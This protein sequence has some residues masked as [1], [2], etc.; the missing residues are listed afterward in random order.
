MNYNYQMI[1]IFLRGNMQ[2]DFCHGHEEFQD[3][4]Y[5]THI[6]GHRLSQHIQGGEDFFLMYAGCWDNL[7]PSN[8]DSK[9][10]E[11]ITLPAME[12]AACGGN[13]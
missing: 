1:S 5:R 3:K 7:K 12:E 4:Q 8:N 2:V 9:R 11:A 10:S 13:G 6:N